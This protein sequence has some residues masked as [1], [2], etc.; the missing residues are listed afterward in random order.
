MSS[1]WNFSSGHITRLSKSVVRPSSMNTKLCENFEVLPKNIIIMKS[2]SAQIKIQIC[3]LCIVFLFVFWSR[4]IN[5]SPQCYILNIFGL[6]QHYNNGWHYV[7]RV[8]RL[9]VH[10]SE[11]FNQLFIRTKVNVKI[12]DISEFL[13]LLVFNKASS[14]YNC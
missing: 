1:R 9:I 13:T 3:L 6:T 10:T 2:F 8:K 11:Y 4:I 12:C 5:F 14:C 7:W